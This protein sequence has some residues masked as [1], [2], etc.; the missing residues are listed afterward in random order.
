MREKASRKCRVRTGGGGG[1]GGGG[2]SGGRIG[3]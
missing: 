2:G 3:K 1:G